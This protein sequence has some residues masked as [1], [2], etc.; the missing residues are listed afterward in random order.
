MPSISFTSTTFLLLSRATYTSST[1]SSTHRRLHSLPP[2][3]KHSFSSRSLTTTA[4][5]TSLSSSNQTHAHLVS[6]T[7]SPPSSLGSSPASLPSSSSQLAS[8]IT[9]YMPQSLKTHLKSPH[10]AVPS[11]CSPVPS[12]LPT[13]T[14][15]HTQLHIY[16]A[17]FRGYLLFGAVLVILRL[18][19][20]L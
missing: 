8:V 14:H 6:Q 18:Y 20:Y 1:S 4:S 16:V 17:A 10:M 2:K 13:T 19:S 12:P 7:V 11:L 9:I 15:T 3:A 5:Q